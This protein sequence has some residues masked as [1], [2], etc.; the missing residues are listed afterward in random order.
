MQLPPHINNA[1]SFNPVHRRQLTRRRR[2]TRSVRTP[3]M[4]ANNPIAGHAAIAMVTT[5]G[6]SQA[7]E[8]S[9]SGALAMLSGSAVAVG[10]SSIGV[11]TCAAAT[12]GTGVNSGDAATAGAS[13]GLTLYQTWYPE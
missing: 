12:V 5:P 2:R 8:P 6:P 4:N 9:I 7:A 3:T 11:A 1:C 10:S 13:S